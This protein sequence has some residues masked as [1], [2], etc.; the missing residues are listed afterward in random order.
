LREVERFDFSWFIPAIV[1]YRKLLGKVLIVSL[2][3]QLIGLAT[4]MFFQVIMDKVLVNHAINTLNVIAVG[5]ICTTLFET[6]L[7][8]LRSYLF[9]ARAQNLEI[10]LA[11]ATASLEAQ[12]SVVASFA[13]RLGGVS[14]G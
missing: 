2:I 8:A 1:K 13:Q 9:A 12:K 10:Q 4:P 11:A 3:L 7:H 6:V 14:T 5:L